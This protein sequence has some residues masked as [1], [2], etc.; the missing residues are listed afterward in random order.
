MVEY[1]VAG[2]PLPPTDDSFLFIVHASDDDL[3]F[4]LPGEPFGAAYDIVFD[5]GAT[6]P[7]GPIPAGASLRLTPRSS[8]LLRVAS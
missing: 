8:T 1:R 4:T 3:D 7:P 6:R 2:E 5:T